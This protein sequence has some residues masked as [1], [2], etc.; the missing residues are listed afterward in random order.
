MKKYI[1]TSICLLF[2][3][4]MAPQ[5]FGETINF[6]DTG[7]SSVIYWPGWAATGGTSK[8]NYLNTHDYY[9]TPNILGGSATI[10]N[11][12]L[13]NVT[14][15]VQNLNS[16]LWPVIKPADLFIDVNNDKYWDYVVNM[17]TPTYGAGNQGLYDIHQYLTDP[18]GYIMSYID[19]YSVRDNHPIGV[20]YLSGAPDPIPVTFGGWQ[21]GLVSFSFGNQNYQGI[22]LVG[23]QFAI[24]WT[25]NC[26]NDVIYEELNHQVPE[27]G[28]LLLLGLG[29]IS[30]AVMN[31]KKVFAK[32]IS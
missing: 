25:V 19:G 32:Q 3:I 10:T 15:N 29:I 11:G 7:A 4:L 13:T 30:L 22:P 18:N 16:T 1:T 2:L 27:P 17:I 6:Y 26:A 8:A 14:F 31:R 9:T 24:G 20:N 23:S 12:Y 28:T 5:V 21:D